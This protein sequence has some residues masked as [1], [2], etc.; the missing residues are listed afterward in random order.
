MG[1]TAPV[2][3]FRFRISMPRRARMTF[4]PQGA[5]CAINNHQDP[6]PK[7]RFETTLVPSSLHLP[8]PE[9]IPLPVPPPLQPCLLSC[10]APCPWPRPQPWV[11]GSLLGLAGK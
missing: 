2:V 5:I 10:P 1:L 6:A 11:P 4:P 9:P 8:L 7:G 3:V